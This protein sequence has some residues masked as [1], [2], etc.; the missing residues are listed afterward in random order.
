MFFLPKPGKSTYRP[1]SLSSCLCKTMERLVVNRLTWWLEYYS[2]LPPSQYGFRKQR[3]CVDNLSILYG[4]VLLA[5]ARG[6]VASALFLD[7]QSAYDTVLPHILAERLTRLG[8]PP[9]TRVFIHSVVSD[10]L[11]TCRFGELEE[12]RR[13]HRGLPQGSVL[14]PLLYAL[15]VIPLEEAC[16]GECRILQYAD[17]VCVYSIQPSGE[18]GVRVLE[19]CIRRI[20]SVLG[21]LGLELSIP[22]TQ[23]CV[24][25]KN[26]RALKVR[27]YV[28]QE[29]RYRRRAYTMDVLGTCVS[30]LSVVTFLGMTFQSDLRWEAH[31]QR[32]ETRCSQALRTIR[33]LGKTWWG[34]DPRLLL[35]VYRATIRSR[36][37][38]GSFLLHNLNRNLSTR[39]DKVQ[40]RAVRACLGYRQSTPINVIL[41]EAREPPLFLRSRYLA[42]NYLSRVAT[43]EN[44]RLWPLLQDLQVSVRPP[45]PRG[46]EWGVSSSVD[47]SFRSRSAAVGPS[48]FGPS[49]AVLFIPLPSILLRTAG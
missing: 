42:L 7:I 16:P 15:Y 29:L 45:P 37:D 6:E 40:L 34:S 46:R 18:A 48:S 25:S 2:L 32:L 23:L 39:L 27:S 14:S 11:L 38:Y 22:K 28:G 17:D 5:F 35:R 44:H 10:R 8:V 4:D 9:R 1:I 24:F 43:N 36:L 41:A 21:D 20:A 31:V 33:C 3:S 12:V 47:G 19:M 30:S 13:V 26:N 49:S